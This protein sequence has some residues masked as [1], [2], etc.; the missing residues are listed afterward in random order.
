[1]VADRQPR[2]GGVRDKGARLSSAWGAH[3]PDYVIELLLSHPGEMPIARD[4]TADAVVLFA[5]I[6]GFTPMSEALARTGSHGTEELTGVLNRW[7]DG[8]SNSIKRYGGSLAEFAGDALTAV[9]RHSTTTR[10]ST[11]RRAVQCALDMQADMVRFRVLVTRAGHFRLAMKVGLA[12]GPLLQ[13]VMGNPAVRLGYLLVGPAVERAAAA[14]H[15]A[16]GDEVV[17]DDGLLA[18][19]LGAEVVE[20]DGRWWLVRG[21]RKRASPARQTAPAALDE[22]AA[23]RLAPF[24]HPAIAER[25]QSGRQELVNEHRKVTAVFVGLPGVQVDD[26]HAVASL[27][28]YLA[29]AVRL[30]EHYGGHLRHVAFGDPGT[31]LVALFGTPVSHEDDEERAVRCSLEL[32][33]L[34]GGPYRAGLGTGAVYCGEVGSDARREYAVIGD[35]VNLAARL[36][37]AAGDGELLI[38]RATYDQVGETTVYDRLR[39]ITVKGKT[40]PI[41]IWA[42]RAVHERP[43][44]HLHDPEAAQPLVGRDAEIATSRALVDCVRSAGGQV[45]SLTG[46]AGIGKSRL[47]A[48]VIQLAGR[49]GF[50]VFGGASRSHGTT[51]SYLVWR[52]IWR[53]LLELDTSLPIADQ[54]A[55]VVDQIA[56]HAAGAGQRAPLLAPVLNVPML[57]SE[58]SASLDPQSRDELLRSLLLECLRDRATSMPI[59]LVL[60]DCHWIDPASAALLDFLARNISDR[61]VL[62]LV[63]AR[64]AVADAPILASLSQLANFT[65]LRLAELRSADAEL[66]VGLRLRER[67]GADAAIQSAVIERIAEQS[68]GNPFYLGELVNYLHAKGVDPRHPKALATLE[69]PDGLQRLLMARLD[70]LSDGEKATIKVA[71]VIGRRF[72]AGWI[73][74]AY[75]AVGG[76]QEVAR[77]L[78]RLHE[79]DLT[80]RRTAAPE[81]EYQFKHAMT[82]EAA[83]QSLTFQ[84]RESLHERVGLLIEATNPERLAQYV[85]VLAHHYGRTQRVDKQ[86]VWFRAAGDAAKAAFANDAAVAYYNR[87]LPL[88]PEDETSDVLVELGGIWHQTG[89]WAEAEQAYRKSMKVASDADRPEILAAGQRDLGD[90]FMY[91]RSYAEAVAWLR[92]AADEFERLG[93]RAGIS[94]TLDR[95]TFALYQQGAYKEAL[96]AA[97]RHRVMAAEA[98]DLSGVSVALNHTG[99]VYLETGRSDEALALL[100]EALDTATKAGDRRCLLHAAANLALAHLRH[101]EH[102]QSLAQGRQAFEVAQEIGFRQT[103][104]VV[105]GNMGEVYRDEGDHVRAIRCF[106]YA[107]R[108]AVELRDWTNVADQVANVAATVAAQGHHRDA[109][110]LFGQAITLA[111]LLDAP[112]LLC[113]WLHRLAKLH[114]EQGRF[115]AAEQLNQEALE[116]AD[117]HDERDIQIRASVLSQR[118]QVTLGQVS[119]NEA[120]ERLRVLEGIWTEPYARALLLDARWHLDPTVET[121]RIA[122]ADL[123]RA[124][125]DRTPDIE[126]GAAHEFLTGATLPQAPPLPP[127][128]APLEDE[129]ADLDELL[130]QVDQITGTE[131]APLETGRAEWSARSDSPDRQP[132]GTPE[133]A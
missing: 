107:L 27:Q 84:M 68:E 34:P 23:R 115:E 97:E 43:R 7:F 62:A 66:L 69:L 113:G 103:A 54:Q 22:G 50:A 110:R 60:E 85:D 53:D 26:R 3:V 112:Y 89:R 82:Q 46:D 12:A 126:Y 58:L 105:V 6:A 45:V 132:L 41:N 21:L 36:M 33:Q 119:T 116:I 120:I 114:V 13:T 2:D 35:S 72:R 74:D 28:R 61:P 19:D 48:E 96:A 111:R 80:P 49:H 44:G 98:G 75:P 100:Q 101:G 121:V 71:S 57:D 133:P 90:L 91:N 99:L 117:A 56:R 15:H 104:S 95:M 93:D 118:L 4:D 16:R 9:F 8:M 94:K 14:E 10:R 47:A 70:Q 78:E 31:V 81:L 24:L 77:H 122:A 83:Y 67:Y 86:R 39:P 55:Q 40:G 1:M 130:V 63:I 29:V 106:V 109:E 42:V 20:R 37:Q 5:D 17:V 102:L 123:Y 30:I 125:Y 51:T 52:S 124:L 38:D 32:L 129:T 128:P 131:A 88:L 76:P 25:L 87:L 79:L 11:T 65:E 18:H 108:I 73:S 92:R 64:G 59:L 127:L